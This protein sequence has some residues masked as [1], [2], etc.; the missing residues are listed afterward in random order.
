M[1]A[2]WALFS[3]GAVPT[4]CTS[5][6]DIMYSTVQVLYMC[7]RE[8]HGTVHTV[9]MLHACPG[10]HSIHHLHRTVRCDAVRMPPPNYSVTTLPSGRAPIARPITGGAH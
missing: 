4:V 8:R 3:S 6:V 10:V 1:R 7:C 9:A 2:W 5:T